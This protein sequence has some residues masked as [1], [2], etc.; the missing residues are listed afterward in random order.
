MLCQVLF[1][2][3]INKILRQESFNNL[4]NFP[5]DCFVNSASESDKIGRKLELGDPHE[6]FVSRNKK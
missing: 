6:T 5:E 3:S 4:E 1:Y 2:I